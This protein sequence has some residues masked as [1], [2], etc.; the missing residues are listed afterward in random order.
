M[1]GLNSPDAEHVTCTRCKVQVNK[2]MCRYWY[3]RFGERGH[4]LDQRPRER[5]VDTHERQNRRADQEGTLCGPCG[6]ELAR[7]VELVLLGRGMFARGVH[8]D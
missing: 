7:E 8:A 4:G 6:D 1:S 5:S 2:L 3:Y